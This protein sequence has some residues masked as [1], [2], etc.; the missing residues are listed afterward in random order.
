MNDLVHGFPLSGTVLLR[1]EDI[2]AEGAG[3]VIVRRYIGMIFQ[4]PKHWRAHLSQCRLRAAH[5]PLQ[6]FDR[7]Q[8][9]TGPAARGALGRG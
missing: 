2:Y 1:G 4:Q 3:P 9:G 5:K 6:R 8:G 7:F